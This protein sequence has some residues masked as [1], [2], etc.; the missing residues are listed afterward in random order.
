MSTSNEL[1]LPP[2]EILD[3]PFG[4]NFDYIIL[5]MLDKNEFCTWSDFIEDASISSSTLSMKLNSLMEENCIAKPEKNRYE[6]TSKGRKRLT[7]LASPEDVVKKLRY[8]PQ[9]I[10]KRRNYDHWILWMLNNNNSARWSDFREKPLAI[11]QSSLSKNLR[12]LIE[13]GFVVNENK[14]Y[15]ITTD[16]R[17]EYL[18]ILKQYDMDRQSI[19]EEE[20]IRI[21]DITEKTRKFFSQY[22]IKDDG[23][24]FRFLNNALKLD[25]SKAKN[26][27]VD[28]EDFDKVLFF[29]S[30]N[31]P[32]NF[33]NSISTEE[34]AFKYKIKETYLKFVI[35]KIIEEEFFPI[36]FFQIKCEDGG[37]YYFQ[38]N[39]A[40]E[41][42]LNAIVEKYIT[43]LT[44]LNKF[45]NKPS[46]DIDFLLENILSD[47]C[48]NIFNEKLKISLKHFL[49]GYIKYL[50]YK[51]ESE[52]QLVDNEAKLEGFVWQNIF[53]EF[54]TFEPAST[55]LKFGEAE[56]YF[57]SL[58]KRIFEVLDIFYLSKIDFLMAD[59][60]Q[61]IYMFN[62][63]E[64]FQK[65]RNLLY[66]NKVSRGREIFEK[67]IDDLN[68]INQLI[69][70]DV[71]ITSEYNFED[72]LKVTEELIKK[73]PKDFIGYLLQSIT[74][75]LMDNYDKSLKIIDK[76]LKVTP[77][78]LLFCQKAQILIK[79]HKGEEFL[80]DLN[81]AILQH[82]HNL[83]LLRIKM[84]FFLTHYECWVN[85]PEEPLELINSII[86]LS[87]KEK[88]FLILK[89]LF[90]LVINKYKEAKRFL[91]NEI[92]INI[93]K[94]NPKID[95]A[96]YFILAFSYIGRGKF[97]KALRIVN[98]L[99]NNYPDHSLSYITK[100]I[101][102]GYNLIYKFKF[103]EP[104]IDTF[105]EL[106]DKALSLERLKFNQMRILQMQ[107]NILNGMKEYEESIKVI[108]KAIELIPTQ[109]N[110]YT[111]KIFLLIAAKREIEALE[112]ID[113]LLKQYPQLKSMLY[114]QKSFIY[115]QIKKYDEAL[116][117]IDDLLKIKPKDIKVINNKALFLAYLER[118]EEAIKTAEYL[119]SLN[120]KLGNSYD[121]Y[122][123][124][125]MTLGEYENAIAKY[126]KAL[127]IEPIGD[128]AYQ[129]CI[130]MGK[131]YQKLKKYD[132]A[133]E[134]YEKGKVLTERMM[135]G[136]RELYEHEA[137][138]YISE[139]RKLIENL[140]INDSMK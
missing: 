2:E 137:G 95:T 33:P 62:Q 31:H 4:K 121:T 20:S 77:N 76:G 73:F 67:N 80:S 66:K 39:E 11:N 79:I 8:P 124:V 120:P 23:L 115:F 109:L 37:V 104:K 13:I 55:P 30:I 82:P 112:L 42:I 97:E 110:L 123:E 114:L 122:G 56:D 35:D 100:A 119:V 7:I 74:Y 25:Y 17:S 18:R 105:L 93:F 26:L 38:K 126:K 63:V 84:I 27:L 91:I 111:T 57:Y 81:E 117:V 118:K 75:L 10:I 45:Q 116:E 60:V 136:N 5:W 138:K 130:K 133:L 12:E 101:V 103:K 107:A 102:L 16:G 58:D 6:I 70:K 40:I 65:F 22:K 44:Y 48:A 1:I 21:E 43:K 139:L 61:E 90:Y 89:S 51:I 106:I 78:I 140:E 125:L 59:E 92:N 127:E 28:E 94:K 34:F 15:K 113:E 108:D 9:V 87:P 53:E 14:K 52:K 129:T 19:L 41:K 128:F 99:F 46:I 88:E 135:P 72:S 24:K 49:P 3:P 47:I 96:V 83:I 71:L 86:K 36:K 85:D 68:D 29:L 134:Y 132:D 131:C 98:S 69:L 54:Q 32:D 64:I 50:A